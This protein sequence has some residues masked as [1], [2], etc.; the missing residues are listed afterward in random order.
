[1]AKLVSIGEII[2]DSFTNNNQKNTTIGGAP[3][4]V[5]VQVD[6]LGTKAIYFSQ[7]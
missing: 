1:M 3:L 6:K 4:N 7:M 5:C 2:A